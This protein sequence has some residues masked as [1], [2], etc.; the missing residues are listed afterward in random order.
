[1]DELIEIQRK[2]HAAL[3]REFL[4]L[5]ANEYKE[6][7]KTAQEQ[8]VRTQQRG[9]QAKLTMTR[10][11]LACRLSR[12]VVPAKTRLDKSA[13]AVEHQRMKRS[14]VFAVPDAAT[15]ADAAHQGILAAEEI[16][17]HLRLLFGSLVLLDEV[18][19]RKILVQIMRIHP[20]LQLIEEPTAFISDAVA[21]FRDTA[22]ALREVTG[23]TGKPKGKGRPPLPYASTARELIE[24]W[25]ELTGERAVYPT[26]ASAAPGANDP[27]ISSNYSTQF[28]YNA[29][30][31]CA[32]EIK[33]VQAHTAIRNVLRAR[34]AENGFF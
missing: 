26:V 30:K 16:A 2:R 15:A 20:K 34:L 7:W 14:R 28:I 21:I 8:M 4:E 5:H 17:K 12:I 13:F 32:P 1:M 29:L 18:Q 31:I 10:L 27:T 6:L 23:Q 33:L 19:R 9:R 3:L 25:E 22:Q 24:L 11:E